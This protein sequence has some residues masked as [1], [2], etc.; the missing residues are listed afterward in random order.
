[1]YS[2]VIYEKYHQEPE[3]Q[4]RERDCLAMDLDLV[5]GGRPD[6][7]RELLAHLDFETH[8]PGAEL[9]R[10]VE[11]LEKKLKAQ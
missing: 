3:K 4:D 5:I 7:V 8:S 9:K 10:L 6:R 1:M 11:E 2:K